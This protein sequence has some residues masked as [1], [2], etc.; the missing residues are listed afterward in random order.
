MLLS[1]FSGTKWPYLSS[2]S[3]SVPR[4]YYL[5]A[6]SK[7]EMDQWV[8]MVCNAC[9][10]KPDPDDDAEHEAHKG[11]RGALEDGELS[12][13]TEYPRKHVSCLRSSKYCRILA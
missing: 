1:V 12:W 7:E 10:F 11:G 5:A 4:L 2:V 3:R 13:E 8:R 9:G 6:N